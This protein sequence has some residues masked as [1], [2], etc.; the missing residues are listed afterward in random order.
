MDDTRLLLE[1]QRLELEILK[2]EKKLAE[3]PEKQAILAA[4]KRLKDIEALEARTDALI[5]QI[6]RDVSRDEDEVSRLSAK[7]ESEQAK[8]LSGKITNPKEVQHI[9]AELDMLR[10]QREKVENEI[11]AQM[12]KRERALGQ[13]AKIQAAKDEASSKEEG[14][15][16][17]FKGKG[18]VLQG[19]I[20]ALRSE[21]DKVLE[22]LSPEVRELYQKHR[23]QRS[24]VIVGVLKG[25]CCGACRME[26]PAETV[27]ELT[28]GEPITE[29]P[30][31]RRILIVDTS[32]ENVE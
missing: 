6:E 27:R 19:E 1:A 25:S 2:L 30:L 3:M 14:L 13:M 24:G 8:L 4:R 31:C 32:V 5:K 29:C 12:E 16:E 18:A 9:S 28:E 21:L 26:L 17:G 10:R 23:S 11:L 20:D 15:V 7:I 22:G